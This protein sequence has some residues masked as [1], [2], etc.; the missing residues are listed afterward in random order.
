MTAEQLQ[1][2]HD[3]DMSGP[4]LCRGPSRVCPPSVSR[5]VDGATRTNRKHRSWFCLVPLSSQQHRFCSHVHLQV[6][7]VSH[8]QTCWARPSDDSDCL[9]RIQ[10]NWTEPTLDPLTIIWRWLI[11]WTG[12]SDNISGPGLP[13]L[14]VTNC[15]SVLYPDDFQLIE[16]IKNRITTRP[17]VFRLL[18]V[19]EASS[20]TAD[21]T[22]TLLIPTSAFRVCVHAEICL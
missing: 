22:R 14:T 13:L 20:R 8:H 3:S 18:A 10:Y 7:K 4:P 2:I 9:T 16:F 5:L 11:L 1:V 21:G 19:T 17:K 15:H 12:C 6:I